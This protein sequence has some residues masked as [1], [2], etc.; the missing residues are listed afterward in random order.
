M[1][2]QLPSCFQS[3][4]RKSGTPLW[5]VLTETG[6][7][8]L[9]HSIAKYWNAPCPVVFS[10]YYKGMD[11]LQEATAVLRT[12]EQQLR[13][14]LVKAAES[15]DYDHLPRI[16]EWAKVL[17]AAL[18]GV[19]MIETV[20]ASTQPVL[21]AVPDNGYPEQPLDDLGG[22]SAPPA[23]TVQSAGRGKK[24][25]KTRAKKAGYPKF[26]REGETLVKIAWSKSERKPYEH[27]APKGVLRALI[28]ALTR[29][30]SGGARFTMEGLLP[31]KDGG[32]DIPDYQ[33]YLTLAWL[34]SAGLITQH[35]RQGYSLPPEVNTERE[36]ERQWSQLA[37]R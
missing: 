17:N 31:L 30:G 33:T 9:C 36:A 1:R 19:T 15:G 25:R 27:K 32:T 37:A 12:A 2:I 23:R 24:S 16:A 3:S 6:E 35:G 7:N 8:T 4:G 28:Q 11:A 21:S 20:P 10:V 18:G 29:V 13:S 5:Q 14:I 26:V 22:T 34:R